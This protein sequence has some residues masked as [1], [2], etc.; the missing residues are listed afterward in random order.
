MKFITIL[1]FAIVFFGLNKAVVAQR[2][3]FFT[4]QWS[5]G[6]SAGF[7]TFNGDLTD[8]TN[9]F[10]SNTPFSKYFYQDRQPRAIFILEKK[11]NIYFGF[12]GHL[13]Y[14][15]VYSTKESVKQYFTANLFEYSLTGTLDFT[16]LFLGADRYRLW[17]IYGYAGIGFTESRTW[18][19]DMV[20][21][22]LIGTNGFGSPKTDGGKYIPMTESVFPLGLG[23]NYQFNK[24]FSAR[25]EFSFHS[26]RTDKLDATISDDSKLEGI[27]IIS[28][29]VNYHMQLP[30]HWQISNR[31]PRYNGKSTDPA[32]KSY[33]KRKRVIMDSKGYRK[34]MKNKKKFNSSRKRKLKLSR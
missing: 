17:G 28:I 32:I 13:S 19:Y 27:G 15:K 16:N 5:V 22:D 9:R 14:G 1:L 30:D 4:E 11:V 6:L 20:T 23:F 18:K 29:G 25:A 3:Y 12:R 2:H 34:G 10:F 24:A 8:K 7:T 33:N 21:G 31:A 26:I